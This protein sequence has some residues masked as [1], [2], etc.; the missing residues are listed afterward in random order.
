MDGGQGVKSITVKFSDQ[1]PAKGFFDLSEMEKIRK[2][3]WEQSSRGIII[4]GELKKYLKDRIFSLPE[5]HPFKQIL[6]ILDILAAIVESNEFSTLASEGFVVNKNIDP[7]KLNK[8]T[9]YIFNHLNETISLDNLAGTVNMHPSAIGRYFKKN[10]GYS[11]V[12]Y[13]NRIRIGNACRVIASG[14]STIS[15]AGYQ[16]GFNNLSHFNRVFRKIKGLTP[17]E[18]LK[19]IGN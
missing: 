8:I 9:S 1:F 12:D 17:T 3:L 16:S 10:T 7:C 2:L 14:E 4:Y 13:I 5:Q 11:P 18:Y 6:Q 19:E 15:E